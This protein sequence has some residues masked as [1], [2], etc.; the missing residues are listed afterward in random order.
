MESDSSYCR[1]LQLPPPPCLPSQTVK[2]T[3]RGESKTAHVSLKQPRLL[4]TFLFPLA[5]PLP[6]PP[7]FFLRRPSVAG[8]GTAT[9]AGARSGV[10]SFPIKLAFS[11]PFSYRR[12]GQKLASENGSLAKDCESRSVFHHIAHPP[13]PPSPLL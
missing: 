1:P 9:R 11:L 13:P 4:L 3:S 12:I 7:Y 2:E 10:F 5:F 8:L 6:L